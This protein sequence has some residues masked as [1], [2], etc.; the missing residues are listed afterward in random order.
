MSR[1]RRGSSTAALPGRP[2]GARPPAPTPSVH[3]ARGLTDAGRRRRLPILGA[4]GALVG[5][6][7]IAALG[8]GV[9]RS[10]SSPGARS[11]GPVDGGSV[12]V[13]VAVGQRAPDFQLVDVDGR[14]VSRESLHGKPALLW[15]TASYCVPCQEGA[16]RL[17][18]IVTDVGVDRI[19]I[20]IVFV[21]PTEP[22]EALR[23]WR[24]RF[25]LPGWVAGFAAGS[26]VGDFRI[27]Y[28]DTK[29]LLDGDGVIRETDFFPLREDV[30]RAA[31]TRVLG[32]G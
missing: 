24:Q 31:I 32:E 20:V 8:F 29:Y 11:S 12:A 7:L 18:S 21:D 25:G 19:A 30:W 27:Q 23:E 1:R 3:R 9:L 26:M 28:L 17:R 15:F 4:V 13:G 10:G 22:P 6:G 2:A 14:A 16:L 5:A